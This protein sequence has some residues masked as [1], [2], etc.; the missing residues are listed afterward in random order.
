M[1]THTA[2]GVIDNGANV[3]GRS[4]LSFLFCKKFIGKH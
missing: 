4:T 1:G 3:V 2:Y